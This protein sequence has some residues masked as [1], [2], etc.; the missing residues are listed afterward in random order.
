MLRAIN[1]K[2][3]WGITAEHRNFLDSFREQNGRKPKILH[4]GNIANNAFRNAE[5]LNR[6]GLQSDVL[7][8]G[9]YHVMGCPEWEHGAFDASGINFDRPDWSSIDLAGYVR[10]RWF[11]Q[12]TLETA[13]AY[14]IARNENSIEADTL[15]EILRREQTKHGYVNGQI[16]YPTLALEEVQ[17]EAARLS[18]LVQ[19]CFPERAAHATAEEIY[20]AIGSWI[21]QVPALKRL[22]KHYD[23]VIGYAT[24][25]ILP[26]IAGHRPYICFEHG[27]I[28]AIPFDGTAIGDICALTYRLSNDT[29]I[30]NCDNIV[31]ANKLKIPS[32]R[33]VPHPMVEEYVEEAR[34]RAKHIREELLASTNSDVI[35][36][37]PP[38]QHWSEKKDTNWEKGNDIIIRAFARFVREVNERAVLVMVRWGQSVDAS[39]QLV[40]RLGITARVKWLEQLPMRGVSAHVA[41]SDVLVDQFVIGAWGGVMPH[42]M[43]LGKP[44]MLYLNEDI[45]RWCLPQM[46]PV[47]NAMDDETAFQGLKKGVSADYQAEIASAGPQWYQRY[48]SE[49]AV[50]GRLLDSF[51]SVL[52]QREGYLRE[53]DLLETRASI[54][55]LSQPRQADQPRSARLEFLSVVRMKYWANKVL[56]RATAFR[57]RHPIAGSVVMLCVR[58]AFA[59]AR[60][61]VNVLR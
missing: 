17:R 22:F 58:C 45:H 57:A 2:S 49:Q 41:A 38:R 9:Y 61:A 32:A 44:T 21:L 16:R 8:Y 52:A 35:V 54:F 5:I 42:G 13:V 12:G 36:F 43:M 10:P 59:V 51:C 26:L 1:S 56:L 23:V 4:I 55:A 6:L 20:R 18:Y 60:P 27:T 40:E 46:P 34:S 19:A 53:Q 3:E 7:C 37:H 14:L 31:A 25:G 15:W 39:E 11:A 50:G 28:R 30:T 47:L 24:D 33:F 29:L 48:H